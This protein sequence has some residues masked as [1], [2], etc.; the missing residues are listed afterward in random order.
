M[1][2]ERRRGRE[3]YQVNLD[4]GRIFWI[5]FLLGIVVI[6]IFIFGYYVGGDKLKK[7]LTTLGKNELVSGGPVSETDTSE[8]TKI[9]PLN[10][11]NRNLESETRFLDMEE[12][13]TQPLPGSEETG[14]PIRGIQTKPF[15]PVEK[16][17]IFDQ[18][19]VPAPASEK[20]RAQ[21]YV[22]REVGDYYIQVASFQKKENADVLAESLRKK[23]Y[24]VRIEEATVNDRLFYRV[25]VGPFETK[26]IARNTMIAMKNRYELKD[27]FVL[28]KDS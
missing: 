10:I 12:V 7:G 27:P 18:V 17:D 22:Y 13:E 28:K 16:E 8:K 6:G 5:A 3:Y 11:F 19:K 26:S 14:E 25:Q 4:T 1:D 23:L 24:K 15:E 21:E 20:L 9:P 2:E